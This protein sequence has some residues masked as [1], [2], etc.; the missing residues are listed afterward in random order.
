MFRLYSL[1]SKDRSTSQGA[2]SAARPL[3]A[4]SLAL[5]AALCLSAAAACGG[6]DESSTDTKA[7]AGTPKAG[8]GGS[9]SA[10]A[11]GNMSVMP[12]PPVQCGSTMCAQPSNPLSGIAAMFGGALGGGAAGLPMAAA[13]C[14]DEG[15]GTCGISTGMG[16]KCESLAT[17]D[18]R[19]PAAD[20]GMLGSFLG[21]SSMA[22]CCIDNMCGQDGKMFG[23]GCVPN[24]EAMSMVA[25]LPL[26]GGMVKF[27]P[28]SACDRP[29]N[30]NTNADDAGMGDDKDAGL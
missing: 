21:G 18:T 11:G 7:D 2:L 22:G 17:P 4:L 9:S 14:L 15:K 26:V 20:L 1:H 24:S 10:G 8:M 3:R 6:D 25:S 16:S 27:P 23:R 30:M 12:P 5:S 29:M 19:C 28:A 13:C